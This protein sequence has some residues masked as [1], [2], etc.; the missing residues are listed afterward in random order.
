[1]RKAGEIWDGVILTTCNLEQIKSSIVSIREGA[2]KANRDETQIDVA[3]FTPIC[4]SNDT[5]KAK[6]K[7]KN[8]AA[9]TI[10]YFPRYSRSQPTQ[11]SR[12][13]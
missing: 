3:N 9:S 12:K 11:D 8:Y 13:K 10:A 5:E 2:N 4:A 6:M 1:M 7:M